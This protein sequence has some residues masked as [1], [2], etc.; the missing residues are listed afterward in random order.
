MLG[1]F[2]KH[3][4]GCGSGIRSVMDVHVFL[5]AC[6]AQLNR[7]YIRRELDKAGL[8]QFEENVRELS[9]VWF[10]D[11]E[12]CG[13][14]QQLADQI[15][16]SGTYGT[17]EHLMENQIADDQ[18]PGKS[19]ASV[20]WKYIRNRVLPDYEWMR[21]HFAVLKHWPVLPPACWTYRILRLIVVGKRRRKV[22]MEWEILS[23]MAGREEDG[24]GE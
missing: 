10:G 24:G 13:Q 23:G 18:E 21:E 15:L 2:A 22:A 20:R 14:V 19:K 16:H 12:M 8:T 5:D 3:H 7:E 4:E 6:G 9:E 11:K 17:L 1:H